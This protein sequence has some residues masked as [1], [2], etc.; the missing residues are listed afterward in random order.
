MRLKYYQQASS[1]GNEKA[2]L[3]LARMYHYGLGI[4]KD[5]KAAAALYQK[6]A[7]RQNAYA[8]YQLGAYYL[9]GT[10]GDR[11]PEKARAL[12]EQASKNGS[13]QA[14]KMLE[15]LNAQTQEKVSFVEPV[16]PN[17]TPVLRGRDADRVYLHA[18]N[19]W[20]HGEEVLSRMIYSV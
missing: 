3:A 12:L 17:R 11:Q 15:Q 20:N 6:L 9:E 10:A 7:D 8:Q 1:Q 19:K 14:R 16:T 5:T 4:A 13:A 18:L 2:M